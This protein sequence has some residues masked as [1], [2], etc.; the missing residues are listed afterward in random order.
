M[1]GRLSVVAV[2]VLGAEVVPGIQAASRCTL[3]A[4]CAYV[5]VAVAVAVAVAEVVAL[6][7]VAVEEECD[8]IID[9]IEVY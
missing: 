1:A 4:S 2:V 5:M 7:G 8:G 6:L 9:V 3:A